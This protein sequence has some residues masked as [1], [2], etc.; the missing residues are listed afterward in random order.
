M[1]NS[2]GRGF[3]NARDLIHQRSSMGRENE[4]A[5]EA[6]AEVALVSKRDEKPPPGCRDNA[7]FAKRM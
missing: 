2:W 6:G 4:E 3:D 1:F 5:A 7:K